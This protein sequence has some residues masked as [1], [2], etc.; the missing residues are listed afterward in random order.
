MDLILE[1][2]RREMPKILRIPLYMS[3]ESKW[4]ET[5]LMLSGLIIK[6]AFEPPK[7]DVIFMT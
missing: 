4:S 1:R 6:S 3:K 7:K 5:L 2:Q